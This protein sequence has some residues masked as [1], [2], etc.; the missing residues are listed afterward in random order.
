MDR[1]GFKMDW[2]LE[3]ELCKR[4]DGFEVQLRL[5][6]IS[7]ALAGELSCLIIKVNLKIVDAYYENSLSV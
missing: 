7:Q 6:S 5:R 3:V 1:R 2:G 4:P